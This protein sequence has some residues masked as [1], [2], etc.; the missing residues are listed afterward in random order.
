MPTANGPWTEQIL[1]RFNGR[2]TGNP[3]ATVLL[4]G[5]GNLYAM[6]SDQYTDQLGVVFEITP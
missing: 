3:Y 4:D 2:P 5:A 1:H 6:T